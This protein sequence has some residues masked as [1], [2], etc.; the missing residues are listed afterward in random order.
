MEDRAT[1]K[2]L[3]RLNA[4]TRIHHSIGTNLRLEEISRILVREL[5]EIVNCDGCAILLIKDNRVE[6]LAESGFSKTSGKLNFDLDMLAIKYIVQTKECIS[7]NDV[8]NSA[9][10]SFLPKGCSMQSLICTPIMAN[11]ES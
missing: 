3:K 4:I 8:L 11:N 10:T 5:I 7:T 6:I 9:A 1:E 2:E